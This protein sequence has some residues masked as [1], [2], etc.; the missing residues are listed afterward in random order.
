MGKRSKS[1]RKRVRPMPPVITPPPEV[2]EAIDRMSENDRKW[3]ECHPEA[4][5]RIRL[6]RPHEFWPTFDSACVKYV[7]VKQVQPGFRL[8]SPILRVNLPETERVQ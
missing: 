2:S 8:R 7:I 4:K 1:S 6:A 3:F 5:E